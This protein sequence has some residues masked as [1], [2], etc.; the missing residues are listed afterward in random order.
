MKRPSSLGSGPTRNK[1]PH[2]KH[3]SNVDPSR[4][5]HERKVMHQRRH[6]STVYTNHCSQ[7]PHIFTH[8]LGGSAARRVFRISRLLHFLQDASTR[9]FHSIADLRRVDVSGAIG[10][11]TTG[12]LPGQHNSMGYS[13]PLKQIY[14]AR[15]IYIKE[16]RRPG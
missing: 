16:K 9:N 1:H 7:V 13:C 4:V 5:P 2:Q 11:V 3:L 14:C 6:V 8:M 15:K 10:S 12:S